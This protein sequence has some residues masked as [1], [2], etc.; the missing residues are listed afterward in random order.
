MEKE[1]QKARGTADFRIGCAAFAAAR[2]AER[3]S[4]ADKM[5]ASYGQNNQI[6]GETVCIFFFF[7]N[8]IQLKNMIRWSTFKDK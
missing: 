5:T 1:P 6:S 7:R 3:R 4:P 8:C 2:T